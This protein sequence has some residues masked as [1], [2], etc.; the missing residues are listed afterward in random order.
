MPV[1]VLERLKGR[2]A[3]KRISILESGGLGFSVILTVLGVGLEYMLF[4]GESLFSFMAADLL[5]LSIAEPALDTILSRIFGIC[6]GINFLVVE[7]LYVCMGFG[8]YINSRLETEGWDLQLDF[9][10][11]SGEHARKNHGFPGLVLALGLLFLG[12]RTLYGEE[13]AVPPAPLVKEEAALEALDRVFAS[14]D[15]GSEKDGW[16]LRPKRKTEEQVERIVVPPAFADIRNFFGRLLRGLIFA[17][18][19]ALTGL[20]LYRYLK[21]G[22]FLSRSREWKVQAVYENESKNKESAAALIEKA[23]VLHSRGLI[24]EAWAC[25]F[26]AILAAFSRGDGAGFPSDATEYGC[27]RTLKAGNN[28]RAGAFGVF[29]DSWVGL[30]YGGREPAPGRFEEALDFCVSINAGSV[31]EAAP[32]SQGKV[33]G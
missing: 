7:S 17:G 27:L 2:A 11:F 1:R 28:P 18:I 12:S 4:A 30:A 22:R 15:F 9:Q 16:E 8:V 29:L 6:Y 14:P 5:E 25:C 19:A 33:Y 23:R 3:R 20:G 26:A 32:P 21:T 31:G 13:G 24:R 10:R